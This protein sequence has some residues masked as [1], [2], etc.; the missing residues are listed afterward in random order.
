MS[1][2]VSGDRRTHRL[3]LI[4]LSGVLFAA[5]IAGS[6]FYLNRTFYHDDAYITLRYAQNLLDGRGVVWNEGEYVQ[7]YTELSPPDDRVGLGAAGIDLVWATRIVGL[8]SLAGMLLVLRAFVTR[9]SDTP[10]L[11]FAGRGRLLVIAAHRV[12]DWWA[13]K[14]ALR[15]VRRGWQSLR[16]GRHR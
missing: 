11:A 5:F 13:G 1:L 10:A 3:Q 16:V 4:Q 7:G 8:A 9:V 15:D 12:V 2:R 6:L 14:H